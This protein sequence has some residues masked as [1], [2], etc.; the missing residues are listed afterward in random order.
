MGAAEGR[1]AI[2][3]AGGDDRA[4]PAA[5]GVVET[6]RQEETD[7]SPERKVF[8]YTYTIWNRSTSP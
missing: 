8:I 1:W 6:G 7:K 5:T 3:G 2:A 4:A